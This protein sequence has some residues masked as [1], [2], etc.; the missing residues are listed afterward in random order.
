MSRRDPAR[1][2]WI[3]PAVVWAAGFVIVAMVGFGRGTQ[4]TTVRTEGECGAIDDW[5]WF[6]VIAAGLVALLPVSRSLREQAT[7]FWVA[8]VVGLVFVATAIGMFTV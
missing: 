6:G 7:P 8:A 1:S 4:C 2:A 3:V 5:L